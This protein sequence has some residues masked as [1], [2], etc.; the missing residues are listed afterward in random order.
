MPN[1]NEIT[2][3]DPVELRLHPLQKKYIP[4]PDK[5]SAEWLSFVDAQSAAGPDG[6][7]PIVVTPE[8]L[9]MEGGR[10]WRAAKQ[11]GWR[12]IRV[13]TR[14]DSVAASIIVESLLGQRNM[15]RCAKVYIAICLLKE[16]VESAEARRFLHLKNG[17]KTLEK[18][19]SSNSTANGKKDDSLRSLAEKFGVS[20]DTVRR[21]IQVHDLFSKNPEVKAE[22]EPKLLCGEKNLWNVLSAIGGANTDQSNRQTGVVAAQ[23]DFWN[24]N[25]FDGL[26]SAAPGWTKLDP[27]KRQIVLADWRTAVKKMPGDLRTAMLVILEE[28]K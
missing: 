21:A 27:Q 1:N 14:P 4:D 10:R 18:P 22:W 26:K 9:I 17:V 8:G 16:F 23:L 7:P 3:R 20:K 19:L 2:L 13:E 15:Q 5:E 6:I 28:E 24:G 25:P 12:E 11:L